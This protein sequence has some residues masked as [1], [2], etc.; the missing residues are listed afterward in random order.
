MTALILSAVLG[1]S[2]PDTGPWNTRLYALDAGNSPR[3]AKPHARVVEQVLP[4]AEGDRYLIARIG[5]RFVRDGEVAGLAEAIGDL[6]PHA[7]TLATQ[8]PTED[9]R[10]TLAVDLDDLSGTVDSP[11]A[12]SLGSDLRQTAAMMLALAARLSREDEEARQ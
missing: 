8:E 6:L 11:H 5:D 4:L 10:N 12:S 7:G 2:N 1:W 3:W 9:M